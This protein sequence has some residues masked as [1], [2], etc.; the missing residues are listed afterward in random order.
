MP[1]SKPQVKAVRKIANSQINK[2][3]ELKF[4]D[5]SD[6]ADRLSYDSPTIN[7]VDMPA[8]GDGQSSRDGDSIWL[9]NYLLR[10][11]VLRPAQASAVSA[12]YRV[13]VVQWLEDN[14]TA[15]PTLADILQD[16]TTDELCLISPYKVDE[17]KKFRVIFDV[18]GTVKDDSGP[19]R[20]Y[21]KFLKPAKRKMQFNAAAVTGVGNFYLIGISSETNASGNG[22]L[23][24]SYHR[25][26][27]LDN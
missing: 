25:L 13:M 12:T 21:S 20:H 8:Q 19:V 27:Y 18:T 22:P 2:I 23:L 15:T 6:A 1:L 3:S 16:A 9:K 24:Y 11:R 7:L 5:T 26:R 4:K 14:A 10:L 17:K